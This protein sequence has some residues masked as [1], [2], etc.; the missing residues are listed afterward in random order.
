MN[1]YIL[2][3]LRGGASQHIA[4]LF[5]IIIVIVVIIPVIAFTRSLDS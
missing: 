5:I 1:L 3:V 2:L 4:S